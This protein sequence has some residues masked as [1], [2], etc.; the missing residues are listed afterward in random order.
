MIMKLEMGKK[1]GREQEITNS[2]ELSSALKANSS[3][4]GEEIP[5]CYVARG[6][7]SAFTRAHTLSG[8]ITP[9]ALYAICKT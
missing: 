5:F 7:I 2:R 1:H 3:S 4:A 8:G 9:S 6:F